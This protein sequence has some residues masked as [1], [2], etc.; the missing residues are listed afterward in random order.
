MPRSKIGPPLYP[1]TEGFSKQINNAGVCVSALFNCISDDDAHV[2]N[3]KG[4]N[5]PYSVNWRSNITNYSC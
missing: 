5:F 3:V 2:L 1:P 4:E